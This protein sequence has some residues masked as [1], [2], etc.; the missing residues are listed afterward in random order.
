MVLLPAEIPST[1]FFNT[2]E[3]VL[4]AEPVLQLRLAFL[5]MSNRPASSARHRL[6]SQLL[7]P[8][9]S[10]G[11]SGEDDVDL[12]SR[13]PSPVPFGVKSWA[14]DCPAAEPNGFG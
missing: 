7:W 8:A 6:H 5:G 9:V 11:S 3:G 1:S 14:S 10:P 4:A 12:T 13:A 2:C